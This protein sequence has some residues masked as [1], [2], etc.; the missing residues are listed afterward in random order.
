MKKT[1]NSILKLLYVCEK[2]HLVTTI[3]EDSALIFFKDLKR[4]NMDVLLANPIVK[5]FLAGS[6]SGMSV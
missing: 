5:S 1:K 3:V 6:F 4:S 2:K